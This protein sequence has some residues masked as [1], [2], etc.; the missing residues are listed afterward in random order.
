M[1]HLTLTEPSPSMWRVSFDNP[2]AP[3]RISSAA[4]SWNGTATSTDSS[5]T[6]NSTSSPTP[7]HGESPWR[8]AT[9]FERELQQAGDLEFR[10]GT[11]GF[12][13]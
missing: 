9:P 4:I 12:E 10:L 11:R 7:S 3:A 2:S 13:V 5:R 6:R 8:T 1:N